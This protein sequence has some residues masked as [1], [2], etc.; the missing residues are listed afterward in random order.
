[1]PKITVYANYEFI[2]DSDN[3]YDNGELSILYEVPKSWINWNE[4]KTTSLAGKNSDKIDKAFNDAMVVYHV[5]E[6]YD[7]VE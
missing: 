7:D 4:G 1:M 6:L 3:C 5:S 2:N